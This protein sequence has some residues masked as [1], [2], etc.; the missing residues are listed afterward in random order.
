[1]RYPQLFHSWAPQGARGARR[2]CRARISPAVGGHRPGLR[3]RLPSPCELSSV[4]A[5][6]SYV[7]RGPGQAQ[8]WLIHKSPARNPRRAPLNAP[9]S[10]PCAIRRASGARERRCG[11]C[12][13][14]RRD[15]ASADRP[16]AHDI[17]PVPTYGPWMEQAERFLPRGSPSTEGGRLRPWSEQRQPIHASSGQ[18]ASALLKASTTWLTRSKRA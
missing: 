6:S 1:M 7:A 14:E 4:I 13:A 10:A 2:G 8:S 5:P 12:P 9:A 11:T 17:H 3:I 16:F 18:A 15:R